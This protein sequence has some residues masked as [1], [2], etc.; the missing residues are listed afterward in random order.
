MRERQ[1]AK[2]KEIGCALVAAG[3]RALDEQAE[4]LG[5]SRSTTW[6][7]LRAT[8]APAYRRQRSTAY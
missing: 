3:F 7:I 2:I 1:S 6:T 8:R 5:L 4:G